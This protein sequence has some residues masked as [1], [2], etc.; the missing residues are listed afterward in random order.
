[1]PIEKQSYEEKHVWFFYRLRGLV[2][3]QFEP[4]GGPFSEGSSFISETKTIRRSWKRSLT[5]ITCANENRIVDPKTE[6]E[7][8]VLILLVSCS[9]YVH[10]FGCPVWWPLNGHE[11]VCLGW[12]WNKRSLVTCA[13][14]SDEWTRMAR[15]M[16]WQKL[17][18]QR[19]EFAHDWSMHRAYNWLTFLSTS[20]FSSGTGYDCCLV[21]AFYKDLSANKGKKI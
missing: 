19:W 2:C 1:M 6:P 12:A 4:T 14:S 8:F 5:E 16:G 21:V 11:K 15:L 3:D 20:F 9:D 7:S 13:T 10:L 18:N 17:T